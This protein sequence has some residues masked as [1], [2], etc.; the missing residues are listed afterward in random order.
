MS[1]VRANLSVI[2]WKCAFPQQVAAS[3]R[4]Q[5]SERPHHPSEPTSAIVSRRFPDDSHPVPHQKPPP[6][7]ND[8][9]T[10]PAGNQTETSL[11]VGRA[12]GRRAGCDTPC[13]FLLSHAA[14]TR[15]ACTLS[16]CGDTGRAPQC[17]PVLYVRV[18]HKHIDRARSTEVFFASLV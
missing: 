15:L 14:C 7:G 11:S 8:I 16:H 2:H 13:T 9:V 6:L 1:K 10:A 3:T 18:H 12:P 4:V 5:G 17:V